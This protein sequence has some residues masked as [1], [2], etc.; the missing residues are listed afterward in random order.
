MSRPS[1]LFLPA[2]LALSIQSVQAAGAG[3]GLLEVYQQA[4]AND[5]DLAAAR[6]SMLASQEAAP[7]ARAAL[8]PQLNAGASL[9]SSHTE[10]A[11]PSLNRDRS[12][13][14]WQASL[15]QPLFRADRWYALKSAEALGEQASLSFSAS[16]QALILQSAE[17]YFGVL[18]ARDALAASR[19]EEAA[20]RRQLDEA[21][22][23]FEVGLSD[24]TDVLEA[25]AAFDGAQA[26]RLTTEQAV[27]DAFQRLATLTGHEQRSLDG[28]RHDLP[29]LPPQPADAGAWVER[30]QN[31]NLGL[32]ASRLAISAAEQGLRQRKAGYAPTVD[33]VASYQ[34]ADN[35]G[36]SLSNTALSAVHYAGPVSS[37]S[38]GLQ[39]NIPIYSGGM[40]GS[41]VR[42]GYQ[43]L[44][45]SEFSSESLRRQVV[46][47]VRN[48][49]RAV[50]TDVA[51]VKARRQAIA[52]SQSALEAT[53][54]GY[55]VGTRN[56]VD[57]LNAQ[58]QLYASV[59]DYND[60][61][62][63]YIIDTLRLQQNAGT[64]NPGDLQQLAVHLN[65]AYDPDRDYLPPVPAGEV[66]AVRR[67][68]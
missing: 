44:Q 43:R 64:L 50:N 7:Q 55:Q 28:L 14:Q 30:A 12:S 8:L 59:R 31:D 13:Y 26:A 10:L 1:A 62:Y 40:T 24:K 45:Q 16:E 63:D 3:S 17:A 46:E 34:R 2:L 66:P 58:R 21:R 15:S 49:Y 48:L 54:V 36:V 25:Q 60:A 5:A 51:R 20:Y 18:R 22:Q 38:I 27:E 56:A 37:R 41:Q 23:R 67:K 39:L 47:N 19:A 52:S 53:E 35:D 11:S 6:A 33:A 65:P 61:R 42:E 32:Q 4:L 29:V 57:V 68:N 9:T